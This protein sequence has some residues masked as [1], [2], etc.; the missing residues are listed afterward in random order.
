[1][2]LLL[3]S[4]LA[5]AARAACLP[6]TGDRIFASDLARADARFEAMPGSVPLAFT[7]PPGRPRTL[8]AAE[9]RR[10][11]GAHGIRLDSASDVCFEMPLHAPDEAEFTDAMRRVL[12]PAASLTVLEMFHSPIPPGPVVFPLT[13]RQP[14]LWRGYVQYTPTRRFPIWARV[15]VSIPFAVHRGETVPVEV[16]SGRATIRFDAIAQKDVVAGGVADLRNP[17]TGRVFHARID[18][19][20]A[21]LIIGTL[22]GKGPA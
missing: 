18:G 14:Q 17:S 7:A 1:M 2:K 13:T 22:P 15:S 12:P 16:H 9:L 21:V 20:K 10:I 3:L 4:V 6:V 8:T 11:A 19:S 5:I